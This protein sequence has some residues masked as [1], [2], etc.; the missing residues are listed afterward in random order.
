MSEKSPK[1]TTET[2]AGEVFDAPAEAKNETASG[3][4][5]TQEFLARGKKAAAELG[6][7]K[8]TE[9]PIKS[10]IL[11]EMLTTKDETG[12]PIEL[13]PPADAIVDQF[14]MVYNGR[15]FDFDIEMKTAVHLATI[16]DAAKGATTVPELKEKWRKPMDAVREATMVSLYDA[17]TQEI[18]AEYT[19]EIEQL[20]D[21]MRQL[22]RSRLP[23]RANSD[24]REK[25][26]AERD[27][28]I[29]KKLGLDDEGLA[30]LQ[31]YAPRR[32]LDPIQ[33]K[34]RSVENNGKWPQRWT[35]G[36]VDKNT[37]ADGMAISDLSAR[38]RRG[39]IS[40]IR[41]LDSM[42]RNAEPVKNL[43]KAC[44]LE[45]FV[46]VRESKNMPNRELILK[47]L[48]ASGLVSDTVNGITKT[49]TPEQCARLREQA[50]TILSA[51]IGEKLAQKER[52]HLEKIY[53]EYYPK[54]V[55]A[56][57]QFMHPNKQEAEALK[58]RIEKLKAERDEKLKAEYKKHENDIFRRTESE[59]G[60]KL[61]P[62]IEAKEIYWFPTGVTILDTNDHLTHK[63][64][65]PLDD[66]VISKLPEALRNGWKRSWILQAGQ[67]KRAAL[68]AVSDEIDKRSEVM[69]D[70]TNSE[71]SAIMKKYGFEPPKIIDTETGRI[72]EQPMPGDAEI[73][74][75]VM[76]S[77]AGPF[78]KGVVIDDPETP[79]SLKDT[80]IELLR[81][82]SGTSRALDL[83]FTRDCELKLGSLR[84]LIDETP[85]EKR[86]KIDERLAMHFALA[87]YQSVPAGL[88]NE[89]NDL[90]RPGS[91]VS[92]M[93]F[94]K[95]Y[96]N[97]I[98]RPDDR[99]AIASRT[100]F[101]NMFAK[102]AA[103]QAPL[104]VCEF[105]EKLKKPTM[106]GE[107]S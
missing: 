69:A 78:I 104:Q 6:I 89:M 24:E 31:K 63:M 34:L 80:R 9:M 76:D 43:Q 11:A 16:K 99:R 84:S 54:Y 93:Q 3:L 58:R 97:R 27:A 5:P 101:M 8:D 40:G 98:E 79:V 14:G 26:F 37:Y 96:R 21:E 102:Y 106:L 61:F 70:A 65:S 67:G 30:E 68:E 17:A 73:L 62:E 57:N 92:A 72:L 20:K 2:V 66:E 41:Y 107:K 105:F 25:V 95:V 75:S 81:Y 13:N 1:V 18:R 94:Y 64:I 86:E 88:V 44:F 15:R 52:K 48:R 85:L 10:R 23:W 100:V 49:Y 77:K 82:L 4:P 22:S 7:P 28:Y 38:L 74:E 55:V 46:K 59:L 12:F 50:E 19:M 91:N 36:W 39:P 47:A 90:V 53:N 29:K 60:K 42:Q 51:Q 83:L 35:S 33:A 71:F 56:N 45:A 32:W 103:G 87:L